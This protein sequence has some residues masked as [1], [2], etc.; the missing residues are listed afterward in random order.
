[1]TDVDKEPVAPPPQ[2]QPVWVPETWWE[3]P[4]R[5][6]NNNALFGP[7][8]SFVP[9]PMEP[10]TSVVADSG[11]GLE[12]TTA[13]AG[14]TPLPLRNP[15]NHVALS[16]STL[17]TGTAQLGQPTLTTGIGNSVRVNKVVLQITAFSL[18]AE[19]DAKLE[20][21]HAD[22]SNSEDPAQF[23]DMRRLVD[24]LLTASGS[25]DEAPVV[26]ATLSLAEGIRQWWTKDHLSICNRVLNISLFTGGLAVC[27]LAGALGPAS[28]PIVA[29]LIAG[30]DVASVLESCVKLLPKRD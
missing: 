18:R 26:S 21:M 4:P 29:A 20:Q 9:P 5:P 10:L 8:D 15:P 24:E 3:P 19:F 6:R 2:Q 13:V 1:M 16:A 23:E 27:G 12:T 7:Q 30:K 17:I 11:G 14:F 22:R 25:D 28:V